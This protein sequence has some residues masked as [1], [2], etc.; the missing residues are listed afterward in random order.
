MRLI[1][2]LPE[3]LSG[4][5]LIQKMSILPTYDEEVCRNG[6]DAERLM[7]LSDLYNIYLPSQMSTEI[8]SKLYLAILRSL[9][10]KGTKLAV[11]Q[12]NSNKRNIDNQGASNKFAASGNR[13]VLRLPSSFRRRG[14]QPDHFME[15]SLCGWAHSPRGISCRPVHAAGDTL[16]QRTFL[17]ILYLQEIN[18]GYG[19]KGKASWRYFILQ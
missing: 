18:A 4:E 9:Q 5:K 2:K 7:K 12:M 14:F 1:E 13:S 17:Q 3:M 16:T 10:K 15:T 6:S 11:Q 8:Y 19:R